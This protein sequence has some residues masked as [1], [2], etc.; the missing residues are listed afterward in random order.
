MTTLPPVFSELVARPLI[1]QVCY[2][3]GD[4][5]TRTERLIRRHISYRKQR[6]RLQEAAAAACRCIRMP[7]A[8]S[9]CSHGLRHRVPHARTIE[10]SQGVLE[11]AQELMADAVGAD[12]AFLST[13]GSSLSVKTA[14]ISVAGPGKNCWCRATP[15]S[16]SS[17]P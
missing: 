10:Q 9:W 14:M 11:Q 13:C 6:G 7:L 12:H 1:D 3:E 4:D 15:T 17:P 5:Q 8:D 2:I 16:R